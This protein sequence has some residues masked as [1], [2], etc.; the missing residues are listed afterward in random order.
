MRLNLEILEY[1]GYHIREL[2]WVGG[3]SKS[4]LLAQVKANVMNKKIVML[5]IQEAGCFGAAMLACSA[6]TKKPVKK[7]ASEW[8]KK[9]S[10][11]YPQ[12]EYINWYS[13]RFGLYK[14]LY[15]NI[16]SVTLELNAYA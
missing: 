15:K 5:N 1:A 6:G 9:I 16:K 8:V 4:Q 10:I 3:G 2:R 12:N 14:E 11:I 7:L 13:K